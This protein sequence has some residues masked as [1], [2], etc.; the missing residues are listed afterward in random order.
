MAFDF[1]KEYKKFYL[2]VSRPAIVK[3]PVMNYLAVR[4][5]ANPNEEGGDYKQAVMI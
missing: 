4:G 2:P 5:N 1:K 3:V